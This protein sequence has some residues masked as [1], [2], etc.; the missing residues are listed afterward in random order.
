VADEG[1]DHLRQLGI[2]GLE[3]VRA[4]IVLWDEEGSATAYVAG[5]SRFRSNGVLE[6]E[7]PTIS[8]GKLLGALEV[9]IEGGDAVHIDTVSFAEGWKLRRAISKALRDIEEVRP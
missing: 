2:R 7:L 3:V 5:P 9:A 8:G 4:A 6:V 1:L